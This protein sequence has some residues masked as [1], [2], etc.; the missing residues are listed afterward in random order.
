VDISHKN[1]TKQKKYIIPKVQGYSPQNS[2]SS[3][4]QS[5]QVRTPQ[6]HLGERR[7]ELQVGKVGKTWE[8]KTWLGEGGNLIWY[9]VMEKD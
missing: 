2:K 6:S 4:S 5:D 7:K 8:G 9:W 1:K 3:T